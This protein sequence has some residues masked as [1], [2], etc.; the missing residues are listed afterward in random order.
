MYTF[1]ATAAL[2]L[3]SFAFAH[4]KDGASLM[5]VKYSQTQREMRTN[6]RLAAEQAQLMARMATYGHHDL[7]LQQR[8]AAELKVTVNETLNQ[9]VKFA[10]HQPYDVSNSASGLQLQIAIHKLAADTTATLHFL[11]E[12][13]NRTQTLAYQEL[14]K[15]VQ[16]DCEDLAE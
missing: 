9:A 6:A 14:L 5:P 16:D 11:N 8:Y 12:T 2:L 7:N 4:A 15:Q 1:T 3:S 13:P 10:L